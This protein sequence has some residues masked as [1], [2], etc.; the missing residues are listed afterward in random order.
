MSRATLLEAF[1]N[2]FFFESI[3]RYEVNEE[4]FLKKVKYLLR[5]EWEFH[6]RAVWFGCTPPQVRARPLQL[7]GWKIHVSCT[8]ENANELLKAVI[9]ILDEND[10]NF[11]FAL[12][13][14]VLSMMNGKNWARQGAG[15]FITIY[16]IDEENFKSLLAK[17]HEV[18]RHFKG[19]YILSD[20][21]YKDSKVLYYRYGG[22]QLFAVPNEKGEDVAML[23]SPTGERVPDQRRPFFF[24]PDWVRD[25]FENDPSDVTDERDESGRIALKEGR[26]LVKNVL[27]FSN[28]G[29]VYVADDTETGEEVLIKEARPFV[30]FTEDAISLLKKEYKLL[31]KLA[32]TGIA[33][34]PIDFFQDW[35]HFFLV[36]E[37]VQGISLSSF[38]AQNHVTLV[39]TPTLADGEKFFESFKT[40]SISVA[41]IIQ[42][43]HEHGI[44][45][46]DVSANNLLILSEP[47][48]VKIIDFE[49]AFEVGVDRPAFVYTPGF[50]YRDQMYGDVPTFESDYFSLGA[51]MHYL[52]APVNQIF[53]ISPRSRFTFINEVIADIG[54]PREVHE[55]M[56]ALIDNAAGERP[57]PEKVVEVLDSDY[58]IRPPAFRAEDESAHPVYQGYVDGICDYCLALADYDRKDRL[59]PAFAM[60]FNTN[61][62]SLSYG[63]CG[64]AHA[65][66]AMGRQVPERVVEWILQPTADRDKVPPGLYMGLAGIAWALLDLGRPEEARRILARGQDH[67]LLSDSS[68]LFLGL[69]G[70]GLANLKF[71]LALR[72]EFYLDDAVKAGERLLETRRESE[73]G[74]HWPTGDEITLGLGHGPSGVALFLLYLWLA[75]A[76]EEFLACGKR[77]LDYDLN[78][79]VP[80]QDDG[81]SWRRHDDDRRVIYPYWRYGSAGVGAALIRYHSVLEDERY[82][83]IVEKI[84][85]DLNRKYAVYPGL[86]IGLAGVGETLLDFHQFTGDDRFL[87]AAYRVST[88]LSLFKIE[89]QEG[90]AFP[91]DGLIKICCDLATGSAGIGR[92]FYRLV[93]RGP[94]P[95]LLDQLL[96]DRIKTEATS[97][98][99]LV[100]R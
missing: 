7:Q 29:G 21:R 98:S 84:Y 66:Q 23:V 48:R 11:K 72:D 13:S 78:S 87:R 52:L 93:H 83:A 9:P 2:P 39:T 43:L 80:T 85:R 30:T 100:A 19:I 41:R 95:L 97:D 62:L 56:I 6:R 42:T 27:G 20:R 25:P 24:M 46:S 74:F 18:T 1:A 16:P 76:R 5:G 55:L 14:R 75:T 17:L 63:A 60:V 91:G 28:A 50:A 73:K 47:L 34:K 45:F 8:L 69:A 54:F 51:V 89:R 96:A 71:F 88:G 22:I 99:L 26:Y 65:I 37:L 58:Q 38:S 10:V 82:E 49:A 92:F 68:D 35:E 31:S 59:F 12:D 94:A 57:R 53:L 77:A 64:V 61:P 15:K 67:P 4:E 36:Q 3:E 81:L 33:P 79:G 40:I 32:H 44:V 90:I 86:F 70:W